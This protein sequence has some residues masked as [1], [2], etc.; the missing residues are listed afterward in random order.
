VLVVLRLPEIVL[1]NLLV[2]RHG[3][4]LDAVFLSAGLGVIALFGKHVTTQL[5]YIYRMTNESESDPSNGFVVNEA[6]QTFH[7]VVLGLGVRF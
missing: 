6:N 1:T 3:A 2:I 7:G 5:G 4:S